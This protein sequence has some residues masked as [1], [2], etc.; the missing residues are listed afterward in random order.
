MRTR[1]QLKII[2]PACREG[3]RH[4]SRGLKTFSSPYFSSETRTYQ[5][6]QGQSVTLHC[7]VKDLGDSTL[8]WKK[9]GRMISVNEKLIR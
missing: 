7:S 4:S 1:A 6:L 2:N 5:V 9:D 8:I 3:V